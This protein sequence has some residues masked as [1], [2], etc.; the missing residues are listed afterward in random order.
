MPLLPKRNGE[1]PYDGVL[2]L[3]QTPGVL[4]AQLSVILYAHRAYIQRFE[5]AM[6][7]LQL[8]RRIFDR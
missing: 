6:E 5:T 2:V 8:N 7:E 4:L 3:P 1:V